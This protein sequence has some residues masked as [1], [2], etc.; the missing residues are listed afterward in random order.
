M[1]PAS[2][3]NSKAKAD[4]VRLSPAETFALAAS[5]LPLVFLDK[6]AVVTHTSV[7]NKSCHGILGDR[8]VLENEVKNCLS[9]IRELYGEGSPN[10]NGQVFDLGSGPYEKGV[11]LRLRPCGEEVNMLCLTKNEAELALALSLAENT[12][13]DN[14]PRLTYLK[15]PNLDNSPYCKTFALRGDEDDMSAYEAYLITRGFSERM[16]RRLSRSFSE[17]VFT[18]YA[19]EKTSVH[20]TG[21]CPSSYALA[22]T[23]ALCLADAVSDSKI[24]SV[25][26]YGGCAVQTEIITEADSFFGVGDYSGSLHGL[27]PC[28]TD[29]LSHLVAASLAA[30]EAHLTA[31]VS[32]R[33][34]TVSI[35]L[36]TAGLE[37]PALDFKYDDLSKRLDS[38][39][40]YAVPLLCPTVATS[41]QE[42]VSGKE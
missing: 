6:N 17:T 27:I 10:A 1:T 11:F 14:S 40:S 35:T 22:L 37:Y 33:G 9:Q 42:E 24:I 5:S 21:L 32:V 16:N 38:L 39:F 7:K 30:E 2:Q 34:G 41:R 26:Y 18:G 19:D 3:K 29:G 25:H 4:A 31:E 23:S 20:V 28:V 13:S 12:I 15:G 8:T 36:V